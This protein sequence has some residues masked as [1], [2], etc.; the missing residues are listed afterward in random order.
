MVDLD[1]LFGPGAWGP[2]QDQLR[3]GEDPDLSDIAKALRCDQPVPTD[4]RDYIADLLEKKIRRKRG[5]KVDKSD[6]K[7]I[8][9]HF[10]KLQIDYWI[11]EYQDAKTRGELIHEGPYRT[12]LTT[13]SKIT[14]IPEATLDKIYYPRGK[15]KSR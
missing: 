9:D 4:V 13:V 11:E 14:R 12:A 7:K 10:L 5:P 2:I 3:R 8:R 6:G 1:E 15:R